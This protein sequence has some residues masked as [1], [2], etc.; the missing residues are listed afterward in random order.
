MLERVVA[1][2]AMEEQMIESVANYAKISK[3]CLYAVPAMKEHITKMKNDLKNNH[4]L[5]DSL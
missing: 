5:Q 1:L 4:G 2:K 3:T